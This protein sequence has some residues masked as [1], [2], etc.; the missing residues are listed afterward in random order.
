MALPRRWFLSEQ[1]EY[2]TT[3]RSLVNKEIGAGGWDGKQLSETAVKSIKTVLEAKYPHYIEAAA[4]PD[5]NA[6][7]AQAVARELTKQGGK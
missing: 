4:I 5:I 7:N 6:V 3:I 1:A 2:L